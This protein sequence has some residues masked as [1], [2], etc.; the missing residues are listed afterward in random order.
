LFLEDSGGLEGFMNL[1][2]FQHCIYTDMTL[3]ID[4]KMIGKGLV[5]T[6]KGLKVTLKLYASPLR[7]ALEVK[8][9]HFFFKDHCDE[10]LD[11]GVSIHEL[12]KLG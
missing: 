6:Y 11:L 10:F 12:I 3:I 2:Y 1:K 7:L 4:K 8:A 5:E 9:E